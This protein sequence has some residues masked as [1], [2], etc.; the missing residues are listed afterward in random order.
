MYLIEDIRN[1]SYSSLTVFYYLRKAEEMLGVVNLEPCVF[2]WPK[3]RRHLRNTLRLWDKVYSNNFSYM[4]MTKKNGLYLL[5]KD[6]YYIYLIC[7]LHHSSFQVAFTKKLSVFQGDWWKILSDH[8]WDRDYSLFM[9]ER[10]PSWRQKR[11]DT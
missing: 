11:K 9:S 10:S 7:V 3:D 1:G 8:L 2:G 4:I 6:L 5:I